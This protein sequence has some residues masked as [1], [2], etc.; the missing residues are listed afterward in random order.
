MNSNNIFK[1]IFPARN[2]HIQQLHHYHDEY[3]R[4]EKEVESVEKNP[5][6]FQSIPLIQDAIRYMELYKLKEA[7]NKSYSDDSNL[8]ERITREAVLVSINNEMKSL[9][10]MMDVCADK[11]IRLKK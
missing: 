9:K 3:I 11:Y 5:E 2:A 6:D 7:V 8:W 4:E 1:L 10:E